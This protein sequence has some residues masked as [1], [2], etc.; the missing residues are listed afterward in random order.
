MTN[1]Y[2]KIGAHQRINYFKIPAGGC[3]RTWW[4]DMFELLDF[5]RWDDPEALVCGGRDCD[6]CGLNMNTKAME[7]LARLV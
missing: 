1:L 7:D 4:M 3:V 6:E 5:V 2:L